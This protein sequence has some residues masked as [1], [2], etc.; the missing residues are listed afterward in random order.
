MLRE[1]VVRREARG[2]RRLRRLAVGALLLEG[3]DALAAGVEVV[4]EVPAQGVEREMVSDRVWTR[5]RRCT[6]VGRKIVRVGRARGA[7][8]RNG[9]R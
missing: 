7:I 8:M 9:Q 5:R 1:L 4:H 6:A 2:V 3:E